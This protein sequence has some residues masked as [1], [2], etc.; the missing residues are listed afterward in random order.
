MHCKRCGL[1]KT[2]VNKWF[3]LCQNC[4][5]TR[6]ASG[7]SKQPVSRIKKLQAKTKQEKK[8]AFRYSVLKEFEYG[9]Y[10]LCEGCRKPR[11]NLDIS[12]II[13]ISLRKDLEFK[14]ENVRAFCRSCHNIWEHG[15]INSIQA[16]IATWQEDFSYI[17]GIDNEYFNRKTK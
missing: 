13:P 14:R 10:L 15:E 4:N 16:N 5:A 12:H 3:S 6:L 7:A 11:A 8:K 2:I 9:G 17:R 1:L